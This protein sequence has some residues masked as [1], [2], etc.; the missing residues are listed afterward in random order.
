MVE[1]PSF[2]LTVASPCS[3]NWSEMTG[4]QQRRFCALCKKHVYDL[5]AMR[6]D[7]VK[8]LLDGPHT[9]CVRFYQREDGTVM[10]ADCPVGRERKWRRIRLR[11]VLSAVAGLVLAAVTY[12]RVQTTR[13]RGC[14]MPVT[15][16]P[17]DA[18]KWA[19]AMGNVPF[20]G[21]MELASAQPP[22]DD[23]WIA[24]RRARVPGGARPAGLMQGRAYSMGVIR[25][26]ITVVREPQKK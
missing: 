14:G 10:T 17:E 8:A 9:P 2:R 15:M 16:Q 11:A 18:A 3:A 4:D 1:K 7:E 21:P 22:A 6:W 19:R 23:K 25:T 5:S 20:A 24:E 13:Y 26:V 12:F